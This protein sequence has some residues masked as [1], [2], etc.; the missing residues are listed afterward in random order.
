MSSV[1]LVFFADDLVSISEDLTTLFG[2]FQ[3][4]VEIPQQGEGVALAGHAEDLPGE[5]LIGELFVLHVP[6]I[7][8]PPNLSSV[9][10]GFFAEDLVSLSEDLATLFGLFQ[11]TVE[12]RQ[13]AAELVVLAG[14][15]EDLPEELLI[16][17]LF[18]LHA[19]II[20]YPPNL[21]SK[22]LGCWKSFWISRK[23]LQNKDLGVVKQKLDI[24]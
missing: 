23:L 3:A 17:E 13:D 14:F 1:F 5:V 22:N 15:A 18:I 2:L 6:I 21:S 24:F 4:T 20:P 12:V 10:L 19:P 7:P 8:C 9:F 16:G 11:A